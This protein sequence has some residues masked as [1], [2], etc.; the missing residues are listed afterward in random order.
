GRE[1]GAG[2]A[3]RLLARSLLRDEGDAQVGAGVALVLGG[4]DRAD[5]VDRIRRAAVALGLPRRGVGAD[6]DLLVELAAGVVPADEVADIAGE[7]RAVG[8]G[9]LDT[10]GRGGEEPVVGPTEHGGE[11]E[12]VAGLDVEDD[13]VGLTGPRRAGR[14]GADRGVE[15]AGEAGA[16]RR[17]GQEALRQHRR[18][19]VLGDALEALA[20]VRQPE[21]VDRLALL[22]EDDHAG[23]DR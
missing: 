10:A 6:G 4:A 9:Q 18:V 11:G 20:A 8:A 7:R 5:L 19:A 14:V 16:G 3:A 23:R 15:H 22:V 13:L 17:R 21:R 2:G 1:R 12:P